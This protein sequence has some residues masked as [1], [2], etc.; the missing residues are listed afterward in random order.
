MTP[1]IAAFCDGTG[2]WS[3]PGAGPDRSRS[4]LYCDGS[5]SVPARLTGAPRGDE[6][7]PSI[8]PQLLRPG[9]LRGSTIERQRV[10]EELH[11]RFDCRI[12]R[13]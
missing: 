12:Y 11:A 3:G 5:G 7:R 13:G 8:E 9:A 2:V 4:G 1:T 6:D 10:H